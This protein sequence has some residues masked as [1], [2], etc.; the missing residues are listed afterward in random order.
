MSSADLKVNQRPLSPHLSIYRFYMTMAMSI[1]HR[2]TGAGLY[3]GTF[4][5]AWWLLAAAT[6]A[7]A[8]ATINGLLG[9]WIGRVLLFLYS[10]TLIHHALGGIRFLIMDTGRGL[11]LQARNFMAR[12]LPVASIALTVVLW[13]IALLA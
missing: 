12:A 11:T 6:G 9:S 13:A 5:I 10:L 7:D 2:I 4:F 3:F 1:L 8:F